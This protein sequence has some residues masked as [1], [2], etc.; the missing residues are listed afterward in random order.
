MMAVNQLLWIWILLK[1][2]AAPLFIFLLFDISR[3]LAITMDCSKRV[4]VILI[5]VSAVLFLLFLIAVFRMMDPLVT[6]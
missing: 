2:I 3:I 5:A 6:R 4:R 1:R